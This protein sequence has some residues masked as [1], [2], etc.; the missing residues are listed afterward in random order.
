MKYFLEDGSW[1]CLRPS[2]TEPKVKFYFA[3]KGETSKDSE[4]R[5]NTLTDEVMK[6]IDSIVKA[7]A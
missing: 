4:A 3:V 7:N 1:F 5:L 6:Q 2:G